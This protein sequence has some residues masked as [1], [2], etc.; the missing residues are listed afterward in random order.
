VRREFRPFVDAK[1]GTPPS[2]PI[3]LAAAGPGPYYFSDWPHHFD[4]VF[5]LFTNLGAANP[6]PSRLAL[7]AEGR[8]FQ[9]YRVNEPP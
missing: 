5:V 9:L 3:F 8:H 4:Y 1:D 2:L 6:D 7:I